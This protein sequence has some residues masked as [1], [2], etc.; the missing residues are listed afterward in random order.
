MAALKPVE[1][2]AEIPPRAATF[3]S[4]ATSSPEEWKVI[5]DEFPAYFRGLTDRVIS[6]FKLL[7]E[8]YGGYPINR[9]EHSLQAAT[10]ALKDGRDEEYVA[11]ALLHDIGDTLCSVNHADLAASILKPF[12]SDKNHWMVENHTPFQGY[13]Y[14]HHIGLDRHAREKFRGHPFFEHTAQFCHLY[15]QNSFDPNYEALKLAD[16]EPML[17]RFF[18]KPKRAT[19]KKLDAA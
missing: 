12:V 6:H 8:P 3:T 2:L 11:C 19:F 9:Y 4:M 7:D 14:F 15:D 5:T 18:A 1:K 13:Y 17:R 16:F 10:R